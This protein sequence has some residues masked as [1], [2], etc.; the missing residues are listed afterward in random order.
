MKSTFVFNSEISCCLNEQVKNILKGLPSVLVYSTPGR[1]RGWIKTHL[2]GKHDL[3]FDGFTVL[4][5]NL[6]LLKPH[7]TDPVALVNFTWEGTECQFNLRDDPK[8][9]RVMIRDSIRESMKE[10]ISHYEAFTGV[11]YGRMGTLRGNV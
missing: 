9:P 4:M 5:A 3:T 7:V 10:K 1:H 8:P 2:E 11:K 6:M